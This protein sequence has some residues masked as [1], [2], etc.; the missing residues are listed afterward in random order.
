MGTSSEG[1]K[2]LEGSHGSFLLCPWLSP[3]PTRVWKV[4]LRKHP[5]HG[6]GFSFRKVQES[7]QRAGITKEELQLAGWQCLADPSTAGL[8]F[9][10][11]WIIWPDSCSRLVPTLGVSKIKT[12]LTESL[13]CA[14]QLPETYYTHGRFN[15]DNKPQR[16]VL[17]LTPFEK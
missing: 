9:M 13:L 8:Q 17:F 16:Q 11:L 4:K 10:F 6:Y 5:C 12:E 2:T 15:T 3:D 1:M 14:R 7:W